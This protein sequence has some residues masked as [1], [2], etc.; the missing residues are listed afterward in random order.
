MKKVTLV[1]DALTVD[2][3][4]RVTKENEELTDYQDHL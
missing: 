3:V 2:L 4:L 1:D